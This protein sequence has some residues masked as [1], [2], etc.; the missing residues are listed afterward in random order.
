[1]NRWL[2]VEPV[3]TLKAVHVVG[4]ISMRIV[5]RDDEC[6]PRGTDS[7]GVDEGVLFPTPLHDHDGEVLH[8]CNRW[9]A[10][11]HHG[12]IGRRTHHHDHAAKIVPHALAATN[13]QNRSAPKMETSVF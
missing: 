3:G 9:T 10:Y 2:D 12:T 5:G 7:E 11:P 4:T 8:R 1:M 6:R 13:I